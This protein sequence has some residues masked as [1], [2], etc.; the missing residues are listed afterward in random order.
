VAGQSPG[1][2]Q[3]AAQQELDLGVGTAQLVGG[4]PGQGVVN[5]GIQPQ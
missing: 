2:G 4:P 3:G 1:I 5:G